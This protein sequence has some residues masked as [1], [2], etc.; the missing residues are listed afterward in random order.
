[1]CG[2]MPVSV[3]LVSGWTHQK[4]F[5]SI[6][7]K[8]LRWHQTQNTKGDTI[9]PK[10]EPTKVSKSHFPVQSIRHLGISDVRIP[11]DCNRSHYKH[12]RLNNVKQQKEPH[13]RNYQVHGLLRIK[14]NPI[15]RNNKSPLKRSYDRK[16]PNQKRKN[17]CA[18][19]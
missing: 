19:K 1:M 10:I 13:I 5:R 16:N 14:S 18:L 11:G 4:L 12:R 8:K 9:K 6:H 7:L 17:L 3:P 2:A 15:K